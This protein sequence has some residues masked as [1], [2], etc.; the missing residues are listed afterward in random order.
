MTPASLVE[1]TIGRY[2]RV[3]DTQ[4]NRSRDDRRQPP[5]PLLGAGY[6][7]DGSHRDLLPADPCLSTITR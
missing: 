1:M 4:R 7:R 2:E 3:G 5:D 6:V